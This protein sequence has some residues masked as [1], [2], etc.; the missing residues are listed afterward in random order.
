MS[1]QQDWMISSEILKTDL[2]KTEQLGNGGQLYEFS[3]SLEGGFLKKL[4]AKGLKITYDPQDFSQKTAGKIYYDK[5]MWF[6]YATKHT[7]ENALGAKAVEE[8]GRGLSD[9]PSMISSQL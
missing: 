3:A 1:E 2:T 9:A 5:K 4:E 8:L 7:L 6:C